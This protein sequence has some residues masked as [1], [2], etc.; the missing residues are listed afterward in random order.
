MQ[1]I[2]KLM[3][4]LQRD[5]D[6]QLRD[7]NGFKVEI[8]EGWLFV[9]AGDAALTRKITARKRYFRLQVKKGKRIQSKGVWA[10]ERIV[11][12]AKQ[13]VIN[14]RQAPGYEKKL[15]YSRKQRDKK[16]AIYEQKFIQAL[17]A[18]LNFAPQYK[19]LEL[20]MAKAVAD[21]AVPVGSGTVARTQMIPIE[22]R[23]SRAVIAWMRHRTTGYDHMQIARIKGERRKIRRMLAEQ[24]S[25][26][27]QAYRLGQEISSNCPLQ[28]ALKA[29]N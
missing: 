10:P 13:A 14:M 3:S 28:M 8:P 22:E 11:S 1:A 6:G 4:D 26:L 5:K 24:S 23:A 21:H 16:Q 2:E 17:C 15:A 27:L 29:R 7:Q 20:K 18:Y 19:E 25:R 9:P 12:E